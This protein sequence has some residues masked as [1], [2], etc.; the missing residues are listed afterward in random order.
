MAEKVKITIEGE[1]WEVEAGKNLL[2][3]ILDAGQVL[4]HF[5]YH[6][7]LGPAG[8]CR[9]CAAQVAPGPDKPSRVEMT[10]MARCADGMVIRINEEFVKNFRRQVIEDLMLNHPHDCPVCDEG[11]ECMLQDMTVLSEHQHRR[12]RFPKRTWKNQYLG[13]LIHHEMNRCITC[14]RCVRYY[15]D[16]ALGDDLGVF[17]SRDRV[18]FG[19]VEDGVLR[20]E[21]SGNLVD[22]C[23]TGVFT[24]KRFRNMYSR[25]WDLQTVKSVCPNCSVGCN[26]LPGFRH[27]LLR[28]IK[29]IGNDQVNRF[30][31]CDRGRYGGEFVNSPARLKAARIDGTVRGME[32]AIES[33][34][35]QLKEIAEV[36]GPQAIAGL[37][38]DRA[39]LEAN[40][41]L[42]LLIQ[43]LGG[44]TAYFANSRERNAIRRAAAITASGQVPVPSL[45]EIE[46]CDFILNLGGDLTGEAPML[47]LSVR[48]AIKSGFP[49]FEASPRG[50]KL[51]QF[52]RLS[53]RT[54]PGEEAR[55]AASLIEALGS[56]E[57]PAGL[58]GATEFVE[59]VV[60][61]FKAAKRPLILCSALHGDLAL[62]EAAYNLA[63]RAATIERPCSLA[64]YYPGSNSVG[65]G[66]IRNDED[67]DALR[68]DLEAGKIK[69][70]VILERDAA[71]DFGSPEAFQKAVSRCKLVVAIDTF[72]NATTAASTAVLPCISHY[73][74]FGTLINYEGRAQR[75][76]GMNLPGPVTLASSEILLYLVQ[77]ASS[78]EG[79]SGTEYHDVFDVTPETSARI[80]ALKPNDAGAKVAGATNLPHIPAVAPLPLPAEGK[81]GRWGI[82]STFGSEQL[83]ALSPP[84]EELSPPP[85]VELHPEDAAARGI[86]EGESVDLTAEAGASGLV[87][88]NPQL[89]RGVVGVPVLMTG[90]AIVAE[91]VTA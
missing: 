58:N 36:H 40:A 63:R 24:N 42:S 35:A 2:Q 52:A 31:M 7:A 19:R 69:A 84:V 82:V 76:D 79:L 41:A 30:F 45:P 81:L 29:P 73:Q 28:R 15:R 25:P 90:T 21:F 16:Y 71:L 43:A 10:C 18:Y 87:V 86:S 27:G 48:Q 61:G 46:K 38:S 55:I 60:A 85:H 11:G 67:P 8:A 1:T 9:L 49:F 50:G 17:G 68:R 33:V 12:N 56:N 88:F 5:C 14:Y 70:L 59:Q 32:E 3:A 74:S 20:S 34:A 22:V 91:E 78:S 54:R 72:E 80:D 53:L 4:P 6:E 83:S 65:V 64:Y 13:P 77:K 26:V 39:S 75:F 62:V 66:L 37:G 89:A 44:R 47:D 23:P 51:S 57:T